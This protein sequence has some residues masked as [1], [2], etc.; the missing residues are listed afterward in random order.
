MSRQI[1]SSSRTDWQTPPD[2]FAAVSIAVGG[3]DIDL[4]ANAKNRLCPLWVGPGSSLATDFLSTM[5]EQLKGMKG[6]INPPYLSGPTWERWLAH[7]NELSAAG[8]R[9]VG[10]LPA[11]TG[12]KW[13]RHHLVEQPSTS[14]LFITGRLK[15]HLPGRRRPSQP[16]HDSVLVLWEA[17]TE[18][19]IGWISNKGPAST[20]GL[21]ANGDPIIDA[22]VV[23]IEDAHT[24]GSV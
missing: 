7:I 6:W 1:H 24:A 9:I 22:N 20:A 17:G 8:V 11:A 5:P 21:D 10:L 19:Q 3:F 2:F 4:A 13:F 15:F 23:L 16:N 12:T 18:K 14:L